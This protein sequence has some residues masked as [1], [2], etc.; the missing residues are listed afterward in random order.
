MPAGDLCTL[1]DVRLSLELPAADTSRDNLISSLITVASQMICHQAE[2][3][4]APSSGAGVTRRFRL[5]ERTLNARIV[6]L[7]PYDLQA[8]TVVSL[9]PES[10][11]PTTLVAN[12]DYELTPTVQ[13][14]SEPVY[15]SLRLSYFLNVVPSNLVRFGYAY[16]DITGTWGFPT[17]P[18]VVN[19][20]C[21]DAVCSWV[22]RDIPMLG[23]NL[24]DG[25]QLGPTAATSLDLPLG[26]LR[27]INPYRRNAGAF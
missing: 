21:S 1:A 20:A 12:T 14:V 23:L 3:E 27:K 5:T 17:V 2:R 22:R 4:F 9:N 18:T 16:L 7:A 8:A 24:Q 10:L 19:E 26:C 15:T 6:D 11:S 25:T 13:P